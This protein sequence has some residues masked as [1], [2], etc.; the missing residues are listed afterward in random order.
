MPHNNDMMNQELTLYYFDSCPFCIKVVQFLNKNN[1]QL[2]MKNTIQDASA[3]SE[4]LNIGGKSQVPCL[5][6]NGTAMY[7]SDDIIEWLKHHYNV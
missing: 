4:L 2:N 5:I 7:E 6:M 3:K 1:I